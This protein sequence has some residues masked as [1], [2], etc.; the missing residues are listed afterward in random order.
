MSPKRSPEQ[1]EED[2]SPRSAPHAEPAVRRSM[3]AMFLGLALLTADVSPAASATLL[4]AVLYVVSGLD[5][6]DIGKRKV[7]VTQD[8][9]SL[10]AKVFLWTTGPGNPGKLDNVLSVSVRQITDCRF[11][12]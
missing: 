4:D 1:R 12:V 10:D 3:R 9:A 7:T 11:D 2:P 5:A 6:H 8:A